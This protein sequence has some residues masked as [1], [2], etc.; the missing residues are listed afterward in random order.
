MSRIKNNF[1]FWILAGY[2]RFGPTEAIRHAHRS[3]RT[4]R[5]PFA[6]LTRREDTAASS[7]VACHN[8]ARRH[9][10]KFALAR[11]LYRLLVNVLLDSAS[12]VP[13]ATTVGTYRTDEWSTDSSGTTDRPSQDAAE[14]RVGD[15]EQEAVVR[16]GNR[17]APF[18]G[19]RFACE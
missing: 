10:S 18:V 14:N 8:V 17:A 7:R 1:E 6:A 5:A 12:G 2:N 15:R 11:D 4:V 3:P 9:Y 16:Q 13:S 19:H